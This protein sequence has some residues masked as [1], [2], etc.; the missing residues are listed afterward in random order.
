MA[1]PETW[2]YVVKG[3]FMN[4][5]KNK[6]EFIL[7]EAYKK[8]MTRS[9]NDDKKIGVDNKYI[10]AEKSLIEHKRNWKQFAEWLKDKNIKTIGKI[11]QETVEEYVKFLAENNYAK[12]T[13][14]SRIGA[15]NKIMQVSG[16][17]EREDR[18]ILSKIENINIK[19]LKRNVYKDLTGNEWISKNKDIYQKNKDLFDTVQAFG[20]RRK[21]VMELNNRSFL[22]DNKNKMYVQTIGK[23]G[24][25]RI[26]EVANEEMNKNML[27]LYGNIAKPLNTANEDKLS[28]TIRNEDERLNI[29][30]ANCHKFGLHIHRAEY[31]RRLLENKIKNEIEI[32]R[33]YKGYSHLKT[34]GL[35]KKE[36]SEI[37]TKIG[38]YKASVK[39]FIEVS[40]NLGHNR[41][42]VLLNYL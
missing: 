8:S 27:R 24:K 6:G 26:A 2:R 37:E 32:K 18:V 17:W 25:Y 13:I 5:L 3:E 42:D 7:N 36:M 31:A 12:K 29:K 33:E 23:G 14:E 35:S 15:V 4:R 41:L 30:G 1:W 40:Q 10:Y 22:I 21:E 16:R 28:R 11:K 39:S 38:T 9:R 20:L 34:K 19:S